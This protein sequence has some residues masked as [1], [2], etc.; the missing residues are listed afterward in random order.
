MV[1]KLKKYMSLRAR[2]AIG[3][4]FILIPMLVLGFIALFSLFS[5]VNALDTVLDK[6]YSEMSPLRG[7]ETK[8]LLCRNSVYRFAHGDDPDA[9]VEFAKYR[10]NIETM[11]EDTR[12]RQSFGNK[13]PLMDAA[14]RDW[15][16][17]RDA[18]KKIIDLDPDTDRAQI[19]ALIPA[20]IEAVDESVLNLDL[21][22]RQT[23]AEMSEERYIAQRI[24]I[25][26]IFR[27]GLIFSLGVMAVIGGVYTLAHS[28][29]E[30]LSALEEGA[31]KLGEGDLSYRVKMNTHNELERLADAF[32][33]MAAKLEYNQAVLEELS[34]R[35]GL[36][37]AFNYREFRRRLSE[38]SDRAERYGRPFSLLMLDLDRFKKVNDT[39]GHP[40]GDEV[41][42]GIAKLL[43]KALRPIDI[44][45]RYGGEEFAIVLPETDLQRAI[46]VAERLRDTISEKGFELDYGVEIRVTA[47]IG[48]AGYPEHAQ[49]EADLIGAADK[50][51]YAAKRSG[52]NRVMNI[53]T[54]AS[55][56]S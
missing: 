6:A 23:M 18:G 49:S 19:L 56:L 54:E 7:I 32:N 21:I 47:S 25:A 15:T 55:K 27:T 17:A 1:D 4:A 51:L 26:A 20:F 2:F 29:L 13:K 11:F 41:L 34:T 40:A 50:A 37:N 44:V 33:Q 3:L 48:V 43:V 39:Y 42:K 12:Q 22:R 31:R 45:A 46:T 30:P 38:E 35:D 5:A 9:E 28:V 14:Y 8:M 24:K 36:T 52:R 16:Q 53:G 10:W